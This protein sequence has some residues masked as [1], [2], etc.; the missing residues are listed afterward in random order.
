M[1]TISVNKFE[2][3]FGQNNIY[4]KIST[5]NNDNYIVLWKKNHQLYIKIISRG[6]DLTKSQK[7][8]RWYEKIEFWTN[9]SGALSGKMLLV[10]IIENK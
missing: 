10:K 3:L 2:Y 9:R 6:F 1:R 5:L 8:K 7:S 4:N